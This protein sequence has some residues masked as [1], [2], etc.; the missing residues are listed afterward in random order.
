MFC[1]HA[2]KTAED[3]GYFHVQKQDEHLNT[4]SLLYSSNEKDQ[5]ISALKQLA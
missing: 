1:I 3:R 4:S 2:R 5:T